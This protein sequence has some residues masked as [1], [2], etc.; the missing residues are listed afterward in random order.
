MGEAEG[1][2]RSRI[3]GV[4][5]VVAV[6][7]VAFVVVSGGN[8]EGDGNASAASACRDVSR[9]AGEVMDDSLIDSDTLHSELVNARDTARAGDDQ[10]VIDGLDHAVGRAANGEVSTSLMDPAAQACMDGG[11]TD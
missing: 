7:A 9:L 8:D 5:A 3:G 1:Q 6:V 4:I 10:D 2:T 11:H